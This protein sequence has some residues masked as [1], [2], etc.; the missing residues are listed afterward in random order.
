MQFWS[1]TKRG[2]F[3]LVSIT[4]LIVALLLIAARNV[5]FPFI[6]GLFLVYLLL[7]AVNFFHDHMPRLLHDKGLARPIAILLIY[8]GLALLLV[9]F[10]VIFVPVVT[11]QVSD[12]VDVA[13]GE[14]AL[15]VQQFA[16]GLNQ[17][18]LDEALDRFY[19]Y[20]PELVR[21]AIENNLQQ[22]TEFLTSSFQDLITGFVSGLQKAVLGTLNVVG[23]TLGFVLALVLIP[24]WVFYL[25][26]DEKKISAAIYS[27]IPERL[28]DDVL[29]L[30]AII[31]E[32]LAAYIRGRLFLCLMVGIMATFGLV[33]L[34]INFSVLLGTIAGIFDIIPN[35][36]PFLGAVPAIVV[37]L[38]KSPSL[39]LQVA[40]MFF[41]VQ[42]IET[43]LLGP[44]VVGASVKLHPTLVIVVLVVGNE[45]AG[46]WGMV[47]GVPITA[48]VRDVFRYLYLRLSD[49]EVS[50]QEAML[51][52]HPPRQMV[53]VEI[54]PWQEKLLSWGQQ[55]YAVAS[56][57]A[58]R[59]YALAIVWGRQAADWSV[60]RFHHL[61]QIVEERINHKPRESDLG[62]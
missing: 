48:I 55:G 47:L 30:E 14:Y 62:D 32:S 44:K 28:R 34:G 1:T 37:A 36:G 17:A 13:T 21:T 8:L 19:D 39:A 16:K 24:F 56:A 5:L 9:G 50:P 10:F 45:V 49:E 7:P 20:M 61:K 38:L 11:E 27:L 60:A 26:N 52:V 33:I 25:L 29:C 3:I 23:T 40:I 53:G 43:I 6:I 59:G 54:K 35:I 51:R 12:L 22:V 58:R 2:R 57:W 46:I 31:G 42:Q 18:V 15:W 4:I 41:V